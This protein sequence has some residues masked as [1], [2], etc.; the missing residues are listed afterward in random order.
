MD[1]SEILNPSC[2]RSVYT[3]NNF[4][5]LPTR[6]MLSAPTSPVELL[7]CFPV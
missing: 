4:E 1:R 2:T 6:K 3:V 5:M 7:N